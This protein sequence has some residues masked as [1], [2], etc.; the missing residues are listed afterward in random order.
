MIRIESNDLA[1]RD[2]LCENSAITSKKG[3]DS[4]SLYRIEPLKDPRWDEL[5]MLHPAASVFHSKAWLEALRR[6]Y[7]Y[8]PISFT[9]SSPDESL[10]NS[11]LFCRVESW[12]TGRRLVSLPFSDYCEPLLQD[13]E[14]LPFFL[15]ALEEEVGMRKWRYIEIR[16]LQSIKI[17]SPRWRETATYTFHQIDLD[18]DLNTLFQNFHK[19]S[20]QRKIR[21]AAREGLT[22]QE[23]STESILDAFYRLLTMTRR[24]HQ[25][26]PQ[27]KSW[28]RNLIACFGKNL[29][30]RI[31]MEQRRPVAAMLTL[32]Y[33]DTLLYKYGGSD[34]RF[35]NL[36][37][38][39]LLYWECIQRAKASGLR[40]FDLGRSDASQG[41][42]ITF[43]SR[44]GAAES[45][46]TYL[47][48]ASSECENLVHS[49][50]SAGATWKT[51]IMKQVCAHAPVSI[52]PLV[53]R[54][55]YKHVG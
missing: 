19:N 47:R 53:G 40:V 7:G 30:I 9:T 31:A 34:I 46:L 20:I 35:N 45:R 12:L 18:P 2:T 23:G 27:P 49:F 4:R 24:R 44:W 41:G 50:D 10:E 16:P 11:F 52:L 22:Y 15:A 3:G 14:D 21:R 26:P 17:A 39:H 51:R 38:M 37:G 6:T 25:V 13:T 29:Q 55:L 42:L 43:K 8:S 33:K 48:C 1:M 54:A 36:G 5:L 32:R 28:F